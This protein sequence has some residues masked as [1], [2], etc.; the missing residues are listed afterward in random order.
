MKRFLLAL[1]ILIPTIALAQTFR[2][3]PDVWER[4]QYG[5]I[6]GVSYVRL[7]GVNAGPTTTFEALWKESAVYSPLAVAMSTPYCASADANDT[8]AGTGA[9]TIRVSGIDTSFNAFTETVTMNGQTSVNLAKTNVQFIYKLEVL[10]AGSGGLNAGIIQCGTGVNTAGDPAVT[11]AYM[12][13]S[14]DTVITADRNQSEMFFYA[15]PDNYSLICKNWT[16]SSVMATAANIYQFVLDTFTNNDIGKRIQIQMGEAGGGNP[17]I[18]PLTL[19]FPEKTIIIGK[20]QSASAAAVQLSAEC[21]LI[22]DFAIN[23]NQTL[24]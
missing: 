10:T 15:V 1:S 9:R 8:S 14:S 17:A 7:I 16:T 4:A 19:K 20:V 3:G 6:P 5:N 2:V 23:A 12:S 24:F 11:H 18:N 22:A 13:A 21:L